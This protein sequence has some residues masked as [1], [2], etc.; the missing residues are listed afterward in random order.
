MFTILDNMFGDLDQANTACTKLTKLNQG[1][2]PFAEYYTKF[3]Y[4]VLKMGY[5]ESSL[6]HML[7]LQLSQELGTTLSYQANKPQSIKKM[8]HPCQSLNN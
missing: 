3:I 2:K 8:V 5:D 1:R 4:Y 6:L 7:C